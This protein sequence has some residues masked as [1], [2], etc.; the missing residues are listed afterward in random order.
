[1]SIS[2][3]GQLVGQSV[4]AGYTEKQLFVVSNNK[5]QKAAANAGG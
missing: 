2:G 4:V 5:D 1:M 3:R